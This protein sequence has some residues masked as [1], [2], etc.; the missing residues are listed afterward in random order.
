VTLKEAVRAGLAKVDKKGKQVSKS[1]AVFRSDLAH[2]VNG[3]VIDPSRDNEKIS[4]EDA[5]RCKLIDIE[6]MV[7]ISPTTGES[8]AFSQAANTG[9]MDVT[10]SEC[11]PKGVSNPANGERIS[12]KQAL[13]LGIVNPRTGQVFN[14]FT[15]EKLVWF[16]VLRPVYASVTMD[17]VYDPTKGYSVPL[18]SALNDG[19]IDAINGMYSN[20]ITNQQVHLDKCVERGLIDKDTYADMMLEGI[21]D[22]RSK[23]NVSLV[24]AV[25]TGLIDPHN[26]TLQLGNGVIISMSQAQQEGLIP[27][28]IC[29]RMKKVDKMTFAEALGKGLLDL[30]NNQF[31]DPDSGSKM[32]ITEALELG[33]ID[34]GSV[35]SMEG[36]DDKNLANMLDSDEFEESSGRIRDKKSGLYLT[37]RQ[38]VDKGVI[39]GDSLLHDAESG[40]TITLDEALKRGLIN[41]DGK[42][43]D[44]K[45]G[46]NFK[47]KDALDQDLL[48]VIP[49]PMQAGQIIAQLMKKKESEGYKYSITAAPQ[50]EPDRSK[51]QGYIEHVS[52]KT[53][54][55]P[56]APMTTRRTVTRS[57]INDSQAVGDKQ[58]EFLDT[59]MSRNFNINEN[60]IEDLR[61]KNRVSVKDAVDSGLLDVQTGEVVNLSTGRRYSVPRAVHMRML[62]ADHAGHIME[63]LNMSLDDLRAVQHASHQETSEE[64]RTINWSGPNTAKLRDPTTA[65]YDTVHL[66]PKHQ[67]GAQ[68]TEWNSDDE[69]EDFRLAAAQW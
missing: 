49:S 3:G 21:P 53:T 50:Q 23:M 5:I 4:I 25:A 40:D 14:P 28:S 63:S 46:R 67:G 62:N 54:H 61:T 36:G 29:A 16:D 22:H 57:V 66:K 33:Y 24:Q 8:M 42:Y 27:A 12:M 10:L 20:P 17:G 38:A 6:K 35:Q 26:R 47:L 15:K 37:F 44:R 45:T 18:A 52:Y 41:S 2:A 11:L 34:T 51:P 43:V 68:C 32:T 59:L 55:S 65:D 9:L 30:A 19:L 64:S 48:A 7:Y 58:Q 39:N 31:T 13:D 1:Y 69:D 56:A 60:V